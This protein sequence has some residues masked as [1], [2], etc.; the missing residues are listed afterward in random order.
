MDKAPK[1][2]PYRTSCWYGSIIDELFKTC[3]RVIIVI[4][5]SIDFFFKVIML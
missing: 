1:H 3:S 5:F 4:F 2:R